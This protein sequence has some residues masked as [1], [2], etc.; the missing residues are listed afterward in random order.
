[1]VGAHAKFDTDPDGDRKLEL[2]LNGALTVDDA[3]EPNG[4]SVTTRQLKAQTLLLLSQNDEISAR[5][6]H[7]A[8]ND[9]N[10]RS[11]VDGDSTA[12]WIIQVGA[13]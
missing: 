13:V 4:G 3:F 10:V 2:L 5:V 6:T 1:L 7:T 12:M 8:G 9:L 11:T